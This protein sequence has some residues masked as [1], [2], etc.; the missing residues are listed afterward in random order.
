MATARQ[1]DWCTRPATTTENLNA[2]CDTHTND[3]LELLRA[4]G[5][6]V[7]VAANG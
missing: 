6:T 4:L 1:C 3:R 2:Y 7:K 5:Y